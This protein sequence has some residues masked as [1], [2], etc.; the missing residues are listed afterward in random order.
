VSF[1]QVRMKENPA[2]AAF[3]PAFFALKKHGWNAE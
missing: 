2:F 3:I 1:V